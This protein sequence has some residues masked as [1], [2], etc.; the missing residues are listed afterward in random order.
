MRYQGGGFLGAKLFPHCKFLLTTW[1]VQLGSGYNV[2]GEVF[3]GKVILQEMG[4]LD[5]AVA[6]GRPLETE[7][8]IRAEA[9]REVFSCPN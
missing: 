7:G 9:L 5:L 3:Y 1:K 8:K 6:G 2:P 4:E